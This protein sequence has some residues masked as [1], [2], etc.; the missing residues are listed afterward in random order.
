M[1]R[2]I[3]EY[4]GVPCGTTLVTTLAAAASTFLTNG[5]LFETLAW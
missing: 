3:A 4:A 1:R 2:M 5:V